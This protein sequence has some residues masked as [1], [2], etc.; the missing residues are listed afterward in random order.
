[1]ANVTPGAPT[2]LDLGPAEFDA[3]Q[4]PKGYKRAAA[5][6]SALFFAAVPPRPAKAAQ[7]SPELPGQVDLLDVLAD[8]GES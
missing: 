6:Q 2:W 5:E 7:L 4:L 3:R 1:M 8:G